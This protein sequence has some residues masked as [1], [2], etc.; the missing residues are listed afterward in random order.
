METASDLA[1]VLDGV[2]EDPTDTGKPPYRIPLMTEIE[3]T[4]L[5]G[6]TVAS[7]FSGCGGSCLGFRMAGFRTVYASEF[8]PAA[9]DTYEANHPGV[10]VDRR[11]IREVT[12][13]DILRIA[14]VDAVDVLEGSPPCAS[15]STAG[16]RAEHWGQV[17]KYSDTEQRTDDLFFEFARI[18]GELQPRVF[19]A[20]NVAGLVKGVAK[21]YF[22][23]IHA[24]LAANGYRVRARVLDAQWLGVPQ[25]RSRVI[26]IGVREDLGRDPVF[27]SPLPYRYTIRDALPWIAGE[28]HRGTSAPSWRREETVSVDEPIPTILADTGRPGRTSGQFDLVEEFVVEVGAGGTYGTEEWRTV[29][30]PVGTIGTSPSTGNGR[31]PSG[32][33]RTRKVAAGEAVD[34]DVAPSLEGYAVGREW[35]TLRPGR[36]SDRY[37]NLVRPNAN[38]PV[39]TVTAAGGSAGAGAPGGVASVTHPTEKRKFTIAELRRLCGFP[40]DFVLTGSY[41]Q[42]WERLG[43]AVPPPMMRAVAAEVEKILR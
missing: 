40:D 41:A 19:V 38:G 8:V 2:N 17:K 12:G 42:Q 25:M 24:A 21:G 32:V 9:A 1:R 33:V 5:N 14:G 39:P 37:L 36:K 27:P 28:V 15:F 22:K 35:E 4:P 18:L 3:Q 26:F 16:R 11:D 29:D 13:A 31:S 34:D 20:E 7:T 30:E 10:P 6:L 23:R 43:R